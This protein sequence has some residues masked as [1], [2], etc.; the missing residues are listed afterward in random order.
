LVDNLTFSSPHYAS[1]TVG[2]LKIAPLNGI[3]LWGES[4]EIMDYETISWSTRKLVAA[5]YWVDMANRTSS[6]ARPANP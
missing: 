2:R 5:S 1:E 4:K 6:L 3:A